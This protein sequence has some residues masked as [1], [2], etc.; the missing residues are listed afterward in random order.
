MNNLDKFNLQNLIIEYAGYVHNE[1]K[2]YDNKNFH[3]VKIYS[4]LH[5][6][7]WKKINE[8]LDKE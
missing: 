5:D 1:Q 6:E 4:R 7:C 2:A 8:I 3:L